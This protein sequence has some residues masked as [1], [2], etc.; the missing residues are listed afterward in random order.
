M[1]VTVPFTPGRGDATQDQTDVESFNV[2]Q[3]TADGFRNYQKVKHSVSAEELLIDRAQLMSLSAPEM[4]VLVAGMR[5]MKTN[6]DD[7]NHGVFTNK[8]EA[9]T[10]DFF[11]NLLDMNTEWEAYY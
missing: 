5:V 10:N 7:S 2:L 9:L 3:P 1:D 6:S 4:S 11:V 8:P